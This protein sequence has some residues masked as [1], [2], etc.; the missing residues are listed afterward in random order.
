MR[1]SGNIFCDNQHYT[2][3]AEPNLTRN[4]SLNILQWRVYY[5]DLERKKLLDL[6]FKKNICIF[7]I[8]EL[9]EF[10]YFFCVG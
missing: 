10:I 4:F 1:Y 7:Q 5:I 3:N 8:L 2:T 9:A 6:L